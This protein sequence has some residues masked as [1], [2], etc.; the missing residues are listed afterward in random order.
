M[1]CRGILA[2]INERLPLAAAWKRHATDYYVPKNLNV[3]YC[4]GF[5]AIFVFFSQM[6]TGIWLVMFYTPS[7][8]EAFSSIQFI[9]R[10]VNYGWLIRYLHT[11][12]ASALFIIL[13]L[14]MFRSLLYGSYKM[15]RE[16]LWVIGVLLYICFLA[17]AFFGYLLPWGQMSYWAAQVIT[18]LFSAL[19]IIGKTITLWLRGDYHVSDATLHR[20]YALHII[21]MPLLM[22]ALVK[23]HLRVLHHVGSN[24]PKGVDINRQKD[25]QGKP[26]D[27]IPLFPFYL[28]K[29]IFALAVFLIV[30]LF[31]VFFMPGLK[32]LFL[33]PVNYLPANPLVTPENIKPMWYM[34]PFYA[35]L[36]A[37]PDKLWGVIVMASSIALLF[38]LPWLD[39]SPVKSIRYRGIYSK[40]ALCLFVISFITL[41]YL[42]MVEVTVFRQYLARVAAVIYFGF[43]AFVP[44]ITRYEV[45]REVPERI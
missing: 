31:V 4:F 9:M 39:K 10:D 43:F 42:G 24:N 18:S 44:L 45:C 6:I 3:W 20:F 41:G 36:R 2:W 21:A 26:R 13:Y 37:I 16:L 8:K 35:M 15:P 32:G 14:H 25:S 34:A 19:P 28:T 27:G 23:L 33:E 17:E 12:G 5:L 7:V 1:K 30:F 40:L 38:V 29:D 22:I 11:T